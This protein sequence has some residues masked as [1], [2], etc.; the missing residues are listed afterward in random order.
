MAFE[1]RW[2]TP[3][4]MYNIFDVAE[5]SQMALQLTSK[6]TK[7]CLEKGM[8]LFKC[9]HEVLIAS[10]LEEIE[11]KLEEIILTIGL[12]ACFRFLL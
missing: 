10:K 5:A 2:D 4:P 1:K 7:L 11:H 6:M 12:L 3:T 8:L 9:S